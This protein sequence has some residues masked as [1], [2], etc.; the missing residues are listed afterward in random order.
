[1]G[2]WQRRSHRQESALKNLL[3]PIQGA[4]N[5]QEQGRA[6]YWK[7]GSLAEFLDMHLGPGNLARVR[8]GL[9]WL[10]GLGGLTVGRETINA[11]HH[12]DQEQARPGRAEPQD[13]GS[14]WHQIRGASR[15]LEG[16][17]DQL[18]CSTCSAALGNS[19]SL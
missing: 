19:F 2:S 6:P 1:M 10:V 16:S 9:R 5:W 4:T 15:Q 11:G 17:L 12:A 8:C 18:S 14:R 3:F 7:K 13:H